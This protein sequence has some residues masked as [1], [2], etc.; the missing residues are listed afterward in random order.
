MKEY[1]STM[2]MDNFSTVG[3]HFSHNKSE[4]PDPQRAES[5]MDPLMNGPM[6]GPMTGTMTGTLQSHVTQP[7]V[8]MSNGSGIIPGMHMQLPQLIQF[9]A[10]KF[11]RIF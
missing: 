10:S 11:K 3:S 5:V 6:T 1:P 7:T 4:P 9:F 8:I 2:H